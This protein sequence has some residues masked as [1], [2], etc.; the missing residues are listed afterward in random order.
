MPPQFNKV[1]IEIDL[2]E[3]TTGHVLI[4]VISGQNSSMAVLY[5]AAQE[6]PGL[7]G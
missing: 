2:I 7:I 6:G 3:F 1:N 5:R 4:H